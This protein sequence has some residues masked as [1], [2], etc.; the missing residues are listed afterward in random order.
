MK[1]EEENDTSIFKKMLSSFSCLRISCF[2]S[3]SKLSSSD[4]IA[5]GGEVILQNVHTFPYTELEIATNG[6]HSSNK[7]GEGGFGSVYKG[8]LEDG[9]VV[10][11]KVLSAESRQGDKEFLSEMDSLSAISHGNLVKLYGGC[12]DGPCRILVYEYMNNGNLAQILLGGKN[13]NNRAKLNWKARRKISLGISEGLAYIHEEIKPRIV[14]RDIKATNILLDHNF[15]FCNSLFLYVKTY[16]GYLAPEYAISGHLTRKSDVY[17]FG[18]LLLEIVSGRTTLDFDLQLGEHYLVEKAWE[19][20]K[21]D[22]LVELVDPMLNLLEEEEEEEAVRF[23]KVALLCVQE[24][25]GLR[26]NMSKAIKM[27]RGEISMSHIEIDEPGLISNFMNVRIIA[28]KQQSSSSIT[29]TSSPQLSPLYK[30]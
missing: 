15:E 3:S 10:A 14:H 11:V 28:Q 7:I 13:N 19:M 25:C 4:D 9:T 20:F 1:I 12:I 24:K 22:K 23:L 8:R 2:S 29:A 21:N 17:S 30:V 5:L 6:F 26:P 16:R 27:M 18:V